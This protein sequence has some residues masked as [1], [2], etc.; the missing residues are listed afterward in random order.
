MKTYFF[1][2][3]SCISHLALAQSNFQSYYQSF[4][5][6][7]KGFIDAYAFTRTRLQPIDKHELS[8]CVNMPQAFGIFGLFDK[9]QGYFKENA[10]TDAVS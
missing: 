6:I 8:S 4:P 2:F 5:S 7:P 1:I 10:K 3:F 9:G